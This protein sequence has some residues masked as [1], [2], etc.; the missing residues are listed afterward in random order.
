M[1]APV[2]I[3][4]DGSGRL[5]AV[6]AHCHQHLI[7]AQAFSEFGTLVTFPDDPRYFRNTRR[8]CIPAWRARIPRNRYER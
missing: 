7:A 5:R 4:A 8:K 1:V 2:I 3:F 6:P